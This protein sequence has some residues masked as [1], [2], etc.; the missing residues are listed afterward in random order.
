MTNV[1]RLSATTSVIVLAGVAGG[2]V[3]LGF[4]LTARVLGPHARR[5]AL[6]IS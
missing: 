5:L 3:F 4:L 1:M 2:L 6:T